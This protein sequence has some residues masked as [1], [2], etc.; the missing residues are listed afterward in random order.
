MQNIIKLFNIFSLLSDR[1][2]A[3]LQ[4]EIHGLG[5]IKMTMLIIRVFLIARMFSEKKNT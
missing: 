4:E 5:K 2:I 1:I 3:C